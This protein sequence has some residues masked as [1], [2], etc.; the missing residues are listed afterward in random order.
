MSCP[1]HSEILDELNS[2]DTWERKQQLWYQM[3]HD[4][5]Q[6]RNKP[7]ANAANLHFPLIDQSIQKFAP[8]YYNQI[9]Q[10]ETLA[11]FVAKQAQKNDYTRAA[12]EFHHYVL[13]EETNFR[14]EIPVVIDTMLLRG[15]GVMKQWWDVLKGKLCFESVDFQHI[16]T[17]AGTVDLDDAD[18][19]V[20]VKHL[21]AHAYKR[22]RRYNQDPALLKKISGGADEAGDD[23]EVEKAQREG[24]TYVRDKNRIVLWEV[25]QKTGGGWTVYTYAPNAQREFIRKP[26]GLVTK[27]QGEVFQPFVSFAFEAKDKGWLSP[28]GVA[29]RLAPYEAWL[30]KVWNS[31]ADALDFTSRPL[32]TSAKDA[33]PTQ[34]QSIQFR[35]GEVLPGGLQR[36]DMGGPNAALDHEM[37]N[38]R[39]IAEQSIAMPDVGI[40]NA[41]NTRDSKTATEVEQIGALMSQGVE[42]RGAI[43]RSPL[44]KVYQRAWALIVQYR[45]KDL[46]YYFSE[47]L[48]V[49]PP[50]ALGEIYQIAPSGSP[51]QWQ[52]E[53]RRQR[54]G[55]RFQQYL[56]NPYV[57]QE[58]LTKATLEEDDPVLVRRLFRPAGLSDA[59][60][61]EDEAIEITALLEHGFP[62]QAMP[63]ENHMLR[64][65]ILVGRMQQHGAL[66]HP[67]DP[68]AQQRLIEHLGQHLEMLREQDPRAAREVEYALK[69]LEQPAQPQAGPMERR[70]G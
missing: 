43:F 59:K 15:R 27:C 67:V 29:E 5:L 13:L 21:S 35:P 63:H 61:A 64:I 18:W 42:M 33:L 14:D 8:F 6:R 37:V 25:Y 62:A 32:F 40:G 9:F 47:E 69:Q 12:A 11:N 3:R 16:I 52:P 31:K 20:H 41:L 68:M 49:M 58:E 51:D 45:K 22:D 55:Q 39:M 48:R 7:Y 26:F 23:A 50:D 53:R 30:C 38:T 46:Q 60:E 44:A 1:L 28:R 36:L 65:K 70:A 56:G 57:D 10:R 54:A 17:P 34:L 66:G 2:R 19:I 24:L 4:G